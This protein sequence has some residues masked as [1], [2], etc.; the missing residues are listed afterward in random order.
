M[1]GSDDI[2]R[3]AEAFNRMLRSLA[4]SRERQQRL[5]ADAGH[6][7]RT[8]L[9]SLRTNIELLAADEQSRMLS[10]TTGRDPR[11]RHRPAAEFTALIGDL[12]HLTRDDRSPPRRSRSTSATWSTPPSNGCAGG[13]PRA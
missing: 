8:P 10:R 9:T 2:T 7:L 3:L 13:H 11:R 6:E 1:S 5:I 4:S 12:V